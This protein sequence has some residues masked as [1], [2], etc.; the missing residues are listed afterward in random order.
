MNPVERK[1]FIEENVGIK[2]AQPRRRGLLCSEV[3]RMRGVELADVFDLDHPDL[4]EIA[5]HPVGSALRAVVINDYAFDTGL[6]DDKRKRFLQVCQA[7]LAGGDIAQYRH[8]TH[9]SFHNS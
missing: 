3:A 9:Y 5:S 4:G 7:S 1:I 2:E 6:T 8:V